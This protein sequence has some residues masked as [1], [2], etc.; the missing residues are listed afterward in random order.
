M[1][2]GCEEDGG[3][4][5]AT[6]LVDFLNVPSGDA[7]ATRERTG[8]GVEVPC[9]CQVLARQ[10]LRA[11]RLLNPP[12]SRATPTRNLSAFAILLPRSAHSPF[13]NHKTTSLQRA[14]STSPASHHRLDLAMRPTALRLTRGARLLR[15]QPVL[16][17][18]LLSTHA[19]NFQPS[20][21]IPRQRGFSHLSPRC[22][23]QAR[24]KSP[25]TYEVAELSDGEYHELSDYYLDIICTK[26]EDLQ[27]M[28]EDVDVEFAVCLSLPSHYMP[29]PSHHIPPHLRPLPS[30][31]PPAPPSQQENTPLTRNKGRR[32]N[33][34]VPLNRHLRH[35]QTAPQQADLA[36]VPSIRPQAVRLRLQERQPERDRGGELALHEGP[37]VAAR[38]TAGGDGRGS[39]E[40]HWSC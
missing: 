20:R 10:D 9:K 32:P 15:P 13:P 31:R 29:S 34:R 14:T 33:N 4:R 24:E 5:F 35:K 36:L 8:V 21:S 1:V 30:L 23:G 19:L 16:R 39:R 27:D 37:H 7:R 22:A 25:V 38:R 40:A 28:R 11:S 3:T 26:Y 12:T 17:A 2:A 6:G 18:P